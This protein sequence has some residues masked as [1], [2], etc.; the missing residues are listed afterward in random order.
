MKPSRSRFLDVRDTRYHVR[1][2][3]HAGDPRLF[4]LHGWGDV[5]ASFQFV[6]DALARDWHVIAPDWRGF[7]LS[8]WNAGHYWFPDYL[9]DLDALLAHYSPDQ[10]VRLVGHSMGGNVACLYAGVRP[11]RVAR[12]AALDAFGLPDRPPQHAPERL[13]TWLEQLAAPPAARSYADRAAFV[14]RLMR[15]NPRLTAERAGFLAQHLGVADD[16]GGVRSATDPAHRIVNPVLYRR[17]EA[18]SCWR[19]ICAPVLWVVQQTQ[20]WRRAVGL[21]DDVY[22]AA[23]SCF[24]D[25]REVAIADSGHNFHHDQPERLAATLEAFFCPDT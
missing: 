15:D 18:E 11:Q 7:G 13:R 23:K 19:E 5:A 24:R 8:A 9:A 12:L 17:A 25:L 1:E 2:W 20:D 6:V 21:S 4:V 3:G 16:G 22:D 10:P 14:R